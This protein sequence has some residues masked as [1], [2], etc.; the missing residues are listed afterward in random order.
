MNMS[1]NIKG[2]EGFLILLTLSKLFFLFMAFFIWITPVQEA[3][4][5]FQYAKQITIDRSKVRSSLSEVTSSG[6]DTGD[7]LVNSISWSHTVSGNNR[8]L[9]VGVS[10]R[11]GGGQTVLDPD[12]VTYGA[13]SLTKIGAIDNGTNVRVE[14]WYLVAPLTGTDTVTVTLAASATARFAAGAISLTNVDQ[15]TPIIGG[16]TSNTGNDDSPTVAVSSASGELVVDT[17]A[18]MNDSEATAGAGQDRQ[19]SPT[20]VS[21]RGAGST[22]PG[23]A[24]VNMS[25]TL[26]T[27]SQWAIG[28]IRVNWTPIATIDNSRGYD[29]S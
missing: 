23:A 26:G 25:W 17:L 6:S 28:A 7:V 13:Q 15:G 4:A 21:V 19:W 16:L 24:S 20:T 12:G 8:L 5:Q 14:M 27:A 11:N 22:E 29:F 10:I 1:K 18:S 2:R 9:I 3:Q